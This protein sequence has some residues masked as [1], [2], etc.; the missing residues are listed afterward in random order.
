MNPT[1][2]KRLA[3]RYGIAP[4]FED[5]RGN[6][7][8][9]DP[10]VARKLLIS[11][12]VLDQAGT[13]L[14]PEQQAILPP[15]IVVR[16]D[17]AGRIAV[18]LGCAISAKQ[19]EWQLTLEDGSSRSG[20]AAVAAAN[21]D[22]TA[23]LTLPQLPHGYHRLV[24]GHADAA[25]M[26]IVTPGECWLPESFRR[27][28]RRYGLSLQL[29]LL[30]SESN[31]GVG[32]FT[33]LQHLARLAAAQGCDVLGLNP[34]HQM[35]PDNPEHASP[36]SP[37]SRQF[38]N[39]LYI[40]V[41]AIAEYQRSAAAQKFVQSAHFQQRLE[42]CRK[43]SQVDYSSVADLKLQALR[44]VHAD[45][46]TAAEAQRTTDYR[47]FVSTAGDGL[48]NASLFQALRDHFAATDPSQ[49]DWHLW[50]EAYHA[51]D[52]EGSL[53]FA[54]E[55]AEQIDFYNWTQWVAEQQLAAAKAAATAAGMQ[56]GLYLDL[57]VGCDRSGSETWAN[58]GDYM[59]AAEVG[60][61]PDIFNPAGQNWGLPP[62][63]P[64]S[65]IAE[66]YRPFIDLLRANMRHGGG[67]R[68]DHAM[69]LQRLYCI[70]EGSPPSAG[71]YVHYPVADLIGILALESQRHHCLVVGED[72]G[73]VPTGFRERMEEANILSY[74]VLFFEA[75]GD[76]EFK[77][78]TSYPRL[79]VAVAGSHD[80]PTLPSW[81]SG[82][83]IALKDQ[84]GLYPSAE[85]T[86][87]QRQ[88]RQ[89]ERGAVMRVLGLDGSSQQI[90]PDVF[91]NAVHGFLGRTRSL[92]AMTQ[93][94][95]LLSEH[96]PVNVPATSTEHPNWRRKYALPLEQIERSR[97]WRLLETLAAGR[98]EPGN[99]GPD[100]ARSSLPPASALQE[101]R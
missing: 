48:H 94:D 40:D 2:I 57:A 69:G 11:M 72:L 36:Y 74:R 39:V 49:A 44:L 64:V 77:S 29:Y 61:P 38:L 79:A 30:R 52:S 82:S 5:A 60:A 12:G 26:L 78:A 68:I 71:A 42:Q 62:L 32:D 37:A 80:L 92:L 56:V 75:D 89:R 101:A 17:R 34:L 14:Q 70:P 97:G 66:G 54:R 90:T 41:T 19:I 31:W 65:L 46:R 15:A 9:T 91:S 3:S 81:L 88:S 6:T 47:R 20:T 99:N 58:P 33:D 7:V 55:H 35:F 24:L 25:T 18:D 63:N 1:Q 27:D 13:R 21:A 93:L 4:S 45:F 51:A 87:K 86:E 10:E 95:D 16:A 59:N 98:A 76:G 43:T 85:E 84:L 22:A 100:R 50:P 8:D 73:T 96:D 53:T 28:E 23:H 83:D 67:L